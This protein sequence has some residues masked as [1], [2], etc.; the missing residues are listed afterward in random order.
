MDLG[1]RIQYDGGRSCQGA[2]KPLAAF[3]GEGQGGGAIG[4][5]EAVLAVSL[6]F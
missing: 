1:E 6:S 3:L 2:A 5:A 4:P